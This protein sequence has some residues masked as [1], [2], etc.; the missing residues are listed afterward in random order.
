MLVKKSKV[1]KELVEPPATNGSKPKY[2]LEKDYLIARTALTR[3][4]EMSAILLVAKARE[5]LVEKEMVLKQAA[6]LLT[7]LRQKLL[8][9]PTS[10]ARRLLH[11]D[12]VTEVVSILKEQIHQALRECADLPQRVTDPNWL[13]TLDE[14]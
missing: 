10:C 11:K 9:I 14:E 5:E 1:S 12:D 6:Y 7:A 2:E 3:A 8:A 13:A 4:R